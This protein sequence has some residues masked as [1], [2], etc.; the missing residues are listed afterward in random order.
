[1][2]LADQRHVEPIDLGGLGGMSRNG[3][4]PPPT[5]AATASGVC[6]HAAADNAS[7]QTARHRHAAVDQL[8]HERSP[9]D[10]LR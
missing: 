5:V 1:V 2:Y 10:V 4:C 7:A 6:I 8:A 9:A 3:T